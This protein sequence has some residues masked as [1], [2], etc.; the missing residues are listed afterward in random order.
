MRF[1]PPISFA[2]DP[3]GSMVAYQ[4]VGSGD[5]DLVFLPGPPSHIGLLWEQPAVAEFL[6]GLASFSRLILFDT[7][8]SGL[9][10]RG[11]QG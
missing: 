10:D 3:R 5:L 1:G 2:R 9:S 8:G 7:V 6:E 4:V 11:S